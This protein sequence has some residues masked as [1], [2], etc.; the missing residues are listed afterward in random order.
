MWPGI[1]SLSSEDFRQ[2]DAAVIYA[3]TTTTSPE[4]SS[5]SFAPVGVGRILTGKVPEDLKGKA[6]QVEHYL[7]DELWNMGPKK[8]PDEIKLAEPE[9]V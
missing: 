7:Y 6:V 5:V 9:Q 2:Y 4:S 1:K 3:Q 8:I